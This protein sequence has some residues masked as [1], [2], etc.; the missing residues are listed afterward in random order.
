MD[1]PFQDISEILSE[2]R[3][4]KDLRIYLGAQHRVR[5]RR[6]DPAFGYE[7]RR[8]NNIA[9]GP[10]DTRRLQLPAVV[11]KSYSGDWSGPF[12]LTQSEPSTKSA[13]PQTDLFAINILN[14]KQA[15]SV[16]VL[17]LSARQMPTS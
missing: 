1:S 10:N 4:K 9:G 7:R 16:C 13:N 12:R 17:M 11:E 6:I 5:H 3:I 15:A 14:P 8:R 2:V